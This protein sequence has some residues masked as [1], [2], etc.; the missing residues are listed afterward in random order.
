MDTGEAMDRELIIERA[1]TLRSWLATMS[2]SS[3]TAGALERELSGI[4]AN[5]PG[6][7]I[8]GQ[9]PLAGVTIDDFVSELHGRNAGVVG[10]VKSVGDAVIAELRAAIP[11]GTGTAPQSEPEPQAAA[12][13][14]EP[15]AAEEAPRPRRPGRPK[16]S[17][18]KKPA[19]AAPAVEAAAPAL[20]A[21]DEWAL[22]DLDEP[23]APQPAAPAPEA[24]AELAPPPAGEP[25]PRKR[26]RPRRSDAPATQPA[27]KSANG[28]R[29]KTA[30][31]A[32]A[33]K[34]PEPQAPRPARPD[35]ALDQLVRL[36]PALH[37]H[38]RRAIVLYASSLMAEAEFSS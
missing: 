25:A 31:A 13:A 26:G 37:P 6:S 11:A 27:A 7:Y 30:P 36:W 34:A 18:N 8:N 21:D 32:P 16:G 10:Q 5:D 17:T 12:P 9:R 2:L 4:I 20:P 19:K 33:A 28:A 23:E 22:P 14:E 38:A 15:A 1:E 24:A 29:R 3:R 35:V